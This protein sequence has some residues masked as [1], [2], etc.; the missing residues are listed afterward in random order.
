MSLTRRAWLSGL[1]LPGLAQT[2]PGAPSGERVRLTDPATDGEVFRLTSPAHRCLLPA[3][4]ARACDKAS[5]QVLHASERSGNWQPWL[6]DLG[7]GA[8]K[9]LPACETMAPAGLSFSFDG[10]LVFV[11]DGARLLGVEPG[12]A[13]YRTLYEAREGWQL[14]GPLAPAEDGTLLL[15]ET[16]A[17]RAELRRLKFGRSTLA[18]TVVAREDGLIAA[19]MNP[20]RALVA[21]RSTAGVIQLCELDGANARRIETPPGRVLAAQW[22]PD[23]Q[24]LL[25]LHEPAAAGQLNAIREQ[26]I[27]SR[28]DVQVA[29]TSQFAALAANLNASVFLGASRS[30][31]SPNV[32]LMLRLTR[33]ELTLCEHKSAAPESTAVQFTPNSQRV[34]FQSE[35]DGAMAIYMVNVERLIEKTDS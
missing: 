27:D 22:S 5:R 14:E 25:Y 23:G 10:R 30:K 34:L 8:L 3:Y 7:S 26:N 11:V 31:A 9:A 1:A 16:Q 13:K 12:G 15:V 29:A 4:P 18:E 33:R 32:L 24:S 21:W 2:R 28:A 20:R 17:G 35:R 19:V 6:V